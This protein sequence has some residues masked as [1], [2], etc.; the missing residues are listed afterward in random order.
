M[1]KI[2]SKVPRMTAIT[3]T[4]GLF[5]FGC[6]YLSKIQLSAYNQEA[7]KLLPAPPLPESTAT[8]CPNVTPIP[9]FVMLK[10]RLIYFLI[11]K[12]GSYSDFTKKA[13]D[14][15]IL[16]LA[17]SIQPGDNVYVAWIDSKP[18]DP[19]KYL[20][21]E[22]IDNLAPPVL[23]PYPTLGPQDLSQNSL[24]ATAPK[25]LSSESQTTKTVLQQQVDEQNAIIITQTAE[26]Q[27]DVDKMVLAA[28]MN[29]L[30]CRQVEIN[31]ANEEIIKVWFDKKNE[32]TNDFIQNT[33]N[34]LLTPPVNSFDDE[35][36]IFEA[37]FIASRVLQSELKTGEYSGAK[38]IIF[39]DM[40]DRRTSQPGN[41]RIDFHSV[42]V[43]TAMMF[44]NKAIFCQDR[45]DYWSSYFSTA[46]AK[47]PIEFKI[48]QETTPD[49]ISEFIL[50]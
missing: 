41:L 8:S 30:N 47:G 39:S 5:I 19:R 23:T 15:A 11:D 10:P 14:T 7:H 3:I 49:T 17:S 29:A 18:E 36:R 16:A 9:T 33:L 25:A 44:C 27:K 21:N 50:K 45:A 6:T 24:T 37:L 32:V 2:N 22:K 12:S 4:I 13:I 38:L 28:K 46:G 42:N 31:Q 43:L 40:D 20:L 35:T 1:S 26:A 48:V 34:P